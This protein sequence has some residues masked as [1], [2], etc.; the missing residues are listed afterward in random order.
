VCELDQ[1]RS[2]LKQVRRGTGPSTSPP[3]QLA[4]ALLRSSNSAP[5]ARH[6]RATRPDRAVQRAKLPGK[7]QASRKREL[8]GARAQR[9]PAARPAVPCRTWTPAQ[10]AR[11]RRSTGGARVS[12]TCSA[13][14]VQGRCAS[15][16]CAARALRRQATAHSPA[17]S[18]QPR[19]VVGALWWWVV[20]GG[21]RTGGRRAGRAGGGGYAKRRC[22]CGAAKGRGWVPHLV[23]A[24][25]DRRAENEEVESESNEGPRGALCRHQAGIVP[26]FRDARA[27]SI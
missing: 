8:G 21:G 23:G 9:S 25:W 7:P 15:R 12:S 17:R 4:T 10:P 16:L 27:R 1:G 2:A 3:A 11:R 19:G 18:G 24:R 6:L 20:G 22:R 5:P 13:E 26:A 14:T